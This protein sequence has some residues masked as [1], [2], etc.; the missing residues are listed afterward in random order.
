MSKS[1]RTVKRHTFKLRR[2]RRIDRKKAAR[3]KK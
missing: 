2:K 3:K 1:K